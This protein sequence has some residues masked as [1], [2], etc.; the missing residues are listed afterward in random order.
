ML[1]L[2]TIMKLWKES[3]IDKTAMLIF[4][5]GFAC[6]FFWELSPMYIVVA[7]SLAGILIKRKEG[8]R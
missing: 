7:A 6:S 5:C 8:A 1:I 3:V 4:A 2:N